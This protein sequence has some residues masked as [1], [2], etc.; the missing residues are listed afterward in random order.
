MDEERA[1]ILKMLEDGKITAQEAE[2]LLLALKGQPRPE[3]MSSDELRTKM[4]RFGL[5][6]MRR[7][8]EVVGSVIKEAV[9]DGLNAAVRKQRFEF[10][11]KGRLLIR[12]VSGD[13][14]VEAWDKTT[15]LFDRDEGGLW[16][17]NERDGVIMAKVLS[18]DL[19]VKAPRRTGL[20]INS[21]SGDIGVT[22]VQ[23]KLDAKSVSG[24]I[25]VRGT[26]DALDISTTS[27]DI[28]TRDIEGKCHITTVSG[29]ID[30][31]FR[32]DLAGLVETRSGDI[33]V[34]VPTDANVSL[35][36]EIVLDG[37]IH[38]EVEVKAEHVDET[39][40]HL[41]LAFGKHEN[42]LWVRCR[43]GDITVH[44]YQPESGKPEAASVAPEV[45]EEK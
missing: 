43:N 5:R 2:K 38:N 3:T 4:R 24:D 1:R 6:E 42:H 19:Q 37:E 44:S 8:P 27:G 20:A 17:A 11:S 7:M 26:A 35:E 14:D 21:V 16:K 9:E 30:L 22:G 45:E 28:K 12:N 32:K 40:H 36:A 10:E 18:G 13:T 31:G 25:V 23:G 34:W 41:R 29:D 33:D 15:V 39:P